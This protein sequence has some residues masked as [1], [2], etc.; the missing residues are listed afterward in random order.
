MSITGSI[1]TVIVRDNTQ[2]GQR[3]FAVEQGP[4]GPP[5]PDP[6]LDPVQNITAEG[7]NLVIDYAQGKHVRLTLAATITDLAVINWPAQNRIARLTLEITNSGDF[8]V[9][10]WPANTKWPDG[11]PPSLTSQG[12]D[13]VILTTTNSGGT[14]FGFPAG[15]NFF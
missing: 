14:I 10:G 6:W 8:D 11:A 12:Q 2:Q 4:V 5:G 15:L 1:P 3:L 13:M 9:T 7:E